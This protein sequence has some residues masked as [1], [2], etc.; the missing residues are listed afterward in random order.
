MGF[1][2]NRT[3]LLVT[4]SPLVRETF[5]SHARRCT[6]TVLEAEGEVT[7]SPSLA[8]VLLCVIEAGGAEENIYDRV[9][10][11]LKA[12]KP[13]PVVVLAR[14]LKAS[15]VVR[16]VRLGVVDVIDLPKP[17]DDIFAQALQHIADPNGPIGGEAITGE[18]EAMQTVRRQAGAVAATRSTVLLVGETGTGKGL[19][20]KTIHDLSR[21]S[22]EP[23]IHVDCAALS[24][25]VIESELFGHERG[26][27]TG[28]SDLRRGR[29]EL[30]GR[31]TVFLDE[32]GDLDTVLQAK[33][34]RVLQDRTY[35]RVGGTRTLEMKARV[36]AATNRDLY[37][38]TQEGRFRAD[39]FYRLNVFEIRIPP[40]RERKSDIPL[41]V[42][43]GLDRLSGILGVPQPQ[44]SDAFYERLMCHSWQGNVR[45]LLNVLERCLVQRRVDTLEPEDLDGIVEEPPAMSP[46]ILVDCPEPGPEEKRFLIRVLRD[47]GWNVTRAARRLGI[48]RSTLRYKIKRYGL[49]SLIPKD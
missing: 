32:I 22:H 38:A 18:G 43:A 24:P 28:A 33:L 21:C 5:R 11:L 23:F 26:A 48:P 15:M 2:A 16:L 47:A 41:L 37:K 31:G 30:A 39:L 10:S 35:E 19:V 29:F 46:E 6:L 44:V 49:E 12:V 14:D 36:I 7:F 8:E 27:F 9:K 20:A 13:S 3:I 40:L 42:R 45:E 25:T 4:V 17:A 34:L 1:S